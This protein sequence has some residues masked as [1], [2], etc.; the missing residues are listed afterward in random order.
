MM[1]KFNKRYSSG[2]ELQSSY[3]LSKYLTDTDSTSSRP[4]DA[5]PMPGW[6]FC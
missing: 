5:S 2:L 1:I 3:K 6:P 4:G